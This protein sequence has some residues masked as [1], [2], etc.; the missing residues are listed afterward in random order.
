MC[1]YTDKAILTFIL[2]GWL[3]KLRSMVYEKVR[4]IWREEDKIKGEKKKQNFAE[5]ETE[6]M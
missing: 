4:I 6:N 3:Y 2:P 1:V 5:Y